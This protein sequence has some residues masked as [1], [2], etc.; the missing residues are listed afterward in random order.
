MNKKDIKN[1]RL[2]NEWDKACFKHDMASRANKSLPRRT[3][4]VRVLQDKPF[5]TARDLKDDVS[6][7]A[8]FSGLQVLR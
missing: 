1:R 3:V 4:S 2:K 7:R 8:P 5:E 6:T